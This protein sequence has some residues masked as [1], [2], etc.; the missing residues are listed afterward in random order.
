MIFNDLIAQ[1]KND[2]SQSLSSYDRLFV[3][4]MTGIPGSSDK[5]EN[6]V[7]GHRFHIPKHLV[8]LSVNLY[9]VSKS[10]IS[11]FQKHIEKI[12]MNHPI[13]NWNEK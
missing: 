3:V 13:R 9:S 2:L 10:H 7:R 5:L 8:D 6:V 1:L 11:S 12:Y 4:Q